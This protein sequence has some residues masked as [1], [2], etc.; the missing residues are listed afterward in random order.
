MVLVIP[1]KGAVRGAPAPSHPTSVV[2]DG[3]AAECEPTNVLK[4]AR[5]SK[6]GGGAVV[7]RG[8]RHVA[9]HQELTHPGIAHSIHSV[10][11]GWLDS[12]AQV[13]RIVSK[14]SSSLGMREGGK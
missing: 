9:V 10:V 12:R 3:R 13:E 7:P 4:H 14:A 1:T 8:R 5:G 6:E 2:P 11:V